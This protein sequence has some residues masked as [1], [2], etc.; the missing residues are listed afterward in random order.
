MAPLRQ[1]GESDAASTSLPVKT[2][3]HGGV[4]PAK[5]RHPAPRCGAGIHGEG[6]RWARRGGSLWAV[7]RSNKT[8]RLR[9]LGTGFPRYDESECGRL[10]GQ[11]SYRRPYST[12]ITAAGQ[13]PR[14][15]NS[16]PR[17]HSAR[18]ATRSGAFTTRTGLSGR[19][20]MR[21][22]GSGFSESCI[23]D[24]TSP[25]RVVNET[26]PVGGLY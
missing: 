13:K 6:R 26:G 22:E 24:A 10:T 7:P 20:G 19:P 1:T 15:G 21:G 8:H 12:G 4:L 16:Q 17:I 9:H 5:E 3:I 18:A 23:S 14:G 2:G 25:N 11:F